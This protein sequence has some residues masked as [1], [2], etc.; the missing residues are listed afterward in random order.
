MRYTA[1]LF[2]SVCFPVSAYA[3]PGIDYDWGLS[4]YYHA[5][6]RCGDATKDMQSCPENG[7]VQVFTSIEV[8]S[9]ACFSTG[10][11]AGFKEGDVIL[12]INGVNIVDM[13][14]D[15]YSELEQDALENGAKMVIQRT[16]DGKLVTK[17][18]SV[19]AGPSGED[20]SCA[21]DGT[22]T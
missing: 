13:R 16:E 21:L 11:A 15:E 14:A 7:A 8:A 12:S 5:T 2:M 19:V 3:N 17:T 20:N 18:L 9:V 6:L 22:H 10:K 4:F 1:A